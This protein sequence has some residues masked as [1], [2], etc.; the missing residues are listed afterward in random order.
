[1][2]IDSNEVPRQLPDNPNLRHL[3]N[4]ARD[5]LKAGGAKSLT[6]AQFKI[7]R[8]YGFPSWPKLKAHV[9]ALKETGRLTDE[10]DTNDV[11]LFNNDERTREERFRKIREYELMKQDAELKLKALR[12]AHGA[13]L[14]QE[15]EAKLKEELSRRA[16]EIEEELRRPGNKVM[17]TSEFQE[18][19]QEFDSKLLVQQFGIKPPEQEDELAE[20]LK[21]PMQQAIRIATAQQPGRVLE[22]R[23]VGRV[24]EDLWLGFYDVQIV[25]EEG[26]ERTFTRFAISA[27][28]GRILGRINMR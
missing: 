8:L 9:D 7:A 4:Q 12:E 18:Q 6:D 3:K 23:S 22:C 24:V 19:E 10:I 27:I 11:D 21:I 16:R 14:T 13:A 17:A 2:S 15:Q 1:M 25:S 5:L 26:A 28:D 20:L